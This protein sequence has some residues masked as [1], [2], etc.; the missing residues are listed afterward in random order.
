MLALGVPDL[1]SDHEVDRITKSLQRLLGVESIHYQ[2]AMGHVYYV[3]DMAKLIAQ[4][5]YGRVNIV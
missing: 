3:N 5:R 4:V 1:P 2:G